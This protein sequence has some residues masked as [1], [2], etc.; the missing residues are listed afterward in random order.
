M[1][2]YLP[3]LLILLVSLASFPVSATAASSPIQGNDPRAYGPVGPQQSGSTTVQAEVLNITSRFEGSLIYS[4][5]TLRVTQVV[6]GLDIPRGTQIVLRIV[7]G[8]VNRTLLWVPDQPCFIVGE[9]VE[10]SVEQQ[11]NVYVPAS[12]KKTLASPLVV[13]TAAGYLLYWY[14]PNVGLTTSTTRPGSDWYGP[15]K[16]SSGNLDYWVNPQGIPSDVS[17]SSFVSYVTASFQTWQDDPNSAIAFTYRGTRTDLSPE[18]RDYVNVVGWL[19]IGGSTVAETVVGWAEYM[20]GDYDYLRFTETDMAFDNSKL[21]SAQASGVSGRYDVQNIG[22]HEAGH[23][24]GLGD[25]YD[26]PADSEQTM[27]GK[28]STGETKKRTLE[29]GDRAGV[30][31]LYPQPHGPSVNTDKTTYAQ[32]DFIQFSGSGFT[33]GGLVLGCLTTDNDHSF[34]CGTPG[35]NADG[36]GNVALGRMQ[37][38]TNIPVGPQKFVARDVSYGSDSNVMQLTIIQYFVCTYVNPSN[39]GGSFT[40]NGVPYIDGQRAPVLAD[41][42]T[43]N[44]AAASVGNYLFDHWSS[45]RS[46]HIANTGQ[47]STTVSFDASGWDGTCL[48]G[49]TLSYAKIQTATRTITLT[50]TST[51]YSTST[52]TTTVTSYTSTSTL[53]STIP[54][55]TTVMLVP[56]TI[57]STEHSTQFLTSFLTTTVTSYTS[58]TTST[59]TIPTTVV[60]VPLTV[61]STIQSTQS[62][63]SILTIT[64]TSYTSTTTSTSTR[65]VYTTVTILGA[66]AASSPLTYLGFMSL[67]ASMIGRVTVSKSRR[68]PKVRS[69]TVGRCSTN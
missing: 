61:T 10:I 7:G 33:P 67:L 42:T 16:W 46:V 44:L 62:L 50:E 25:M 36:Q 45:V 66:A 13:A 31:T 51:S 6:A 55:V 14:K 53:T 5:V 34:I 54:T 23:T 29:W 60:L 59:S 9:R 4:Y 40:L 57:T 17:T 63:T 24:F 12:Q 58:T 52:R 26:L 64:E 15:L 1:P 11:G 20:P 38:G 8:E 30:A 2:S 49:L 19:S 68:I 65:V 48:G 22:T 37:V 32:G 27:Y 18:S 69:L 35:A 56:L 43:Y 21:W 41:G 39:I 3:F 47:S 28:V